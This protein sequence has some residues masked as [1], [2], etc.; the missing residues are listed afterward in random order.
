M[1]SLFALSRYLK[2]DV[3]LLT[4]VDSIFREE[5]FAR[6]LLHAQHQRADGVLAVTN[7]IDDENPLYV[8]MDQMLRIQS[9]SKSEQSLWVTGGLYIFHPRIFQE[10]DKVLEQKIERL[11]NFLS[12]LLLHGYALEGFPFSKIIDVDH[13][14]D[15]HVAE[16]LLR[17][18]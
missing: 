14:R 7:F 15:I 8:Q 18:H 5:E 9:F 1:H 3:F 4:T 11:R 16:E 2:D 6:Y 12:Y 13:A 10:I 17:T